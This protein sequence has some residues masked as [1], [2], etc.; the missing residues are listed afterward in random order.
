MTPKELQ[1]EVFYLI[2][3][4]K[5]SNVNLNENFFISVTSTL[6]MAYKVQ[7]DDLEFKTSL[8]FGIWGTNKEIEVE[9]ILEKIKTELRDSNIKN[10]LD[11]L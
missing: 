9:E 4:V 10:I 2:D 6:N 7:I 5:K 8:Y 3:K 11:E 1:D